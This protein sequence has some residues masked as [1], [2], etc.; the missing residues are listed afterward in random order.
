MIQE[1]RQEI[2]ETV[3]GILTEFNNSD[4]LRFA[5]LGQQYLLMRDVLKLTYDMDIREI[6]PNGSVRVDDEISNEHFFKMLEDVLIKK[7]YKLATSHILDQVVYNA[8]SRN[9]TKDP[10]ALFVLDSIKENGAYL[11]GKARDL[12]GTEYLGKPIRGQ[13]VYDVI[14]NELHATFL[15][16]RGKAQLTFKPL[17][18]VDSTIDIFSNFNI[19]AADAANYLVSLRDEGID[20]LREE[21]GNVYNEVYAVLETGRIPKQDGGFVKV[22]QLSRGSFKTLVIDK[23]MKQGEVGLEKYLP[24]QCGR[25]RELYK[26][27]GEKRTENNEK[28]K[29]QIDLVKDSLVDGNFSSSLAKQNTNDNRLLFE[30]FNGMVGYNG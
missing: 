2:Q 29:A 10:F 15:D 22:K 24:E 25:L 28:Y 14:K 16:R 19:P 9:G 30:V 8:E 13:Q 12:V 20:G 6:E 23:M 4:T 7:N 3:R 27:V 5:D 1:K 17:L 26:Q 21:F 18:D 11:I